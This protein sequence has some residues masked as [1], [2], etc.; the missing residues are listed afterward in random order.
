MIEKK[1][2]DNSIN[3]NNTNNETINHETNEELMEIVPIDI[4]NNISNY[5]ANSNL[6]IN[7]HE[8]VEEETEHE[9]HKQESDQVVLHQEISEND[10]QH[11]KIN[12]LK[13]PTKSP[14]NPNNKKV[15]F[16]PSFHYDDY[17]GIILTLNR[18]V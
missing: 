3:I 13:N 7:N 18:D 9:Q 6:S 10:Q 11:P 16:S 1:L 17:C 12:G 2:I 8:E 5:S 4:D 14:K 15:I